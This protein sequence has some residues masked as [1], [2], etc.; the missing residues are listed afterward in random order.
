MAVYT[1]TVKLDDQ[2]TAPAKSAEK[3]MGGLEKATLANIATQGKMANVMAS[4]RD[5]VSSSV[6]GMRSAFS[7]L[8]GGDVRG[9]I[10]GVTDSIAGMAKLLDLVVPGL[11]Q[12]ASILIQIAGGFAGVAAMIVKGG[13]ELAISSSAAK[14]EML[15]LFDAMGQGVVSGEALEGVID[16]LKDKF[17]ISKDRMAGYANELQKLGVTDL[18]KLE[19]GILAMSSA[20]ALSKNG[21]NALLEFQKRIKLAADSGETL[22][23]ADKQLRS[24]G[25]TGA[26]LGAIA[27]IMGT[28]IEKLRSGLKNGTVDAAKF[29]DALEKAVI[30]KGSKALDRLA[31]SAG[32]LKAKWNE[33]IGDLFEDL[34]DSTGP[35][36]AEVGKLLA[37]FSQST[38]SGK[39]MKAGVTAA[40]SAILGVATKVVPYIV[41]FLKDIVIL[42]LKAYIAV[43]PLIAR[44]DA[45]A[46]SADG[47]KT[48]ETIM[49]ALWTVLKGVGV[50]VLIVAGYFGV[51]VAAMTAVSIAVW[52]AVGAFAS[53]A[54]DTAAALAAWVSTAAS[55]AYN[56]VAGL[57]AGISGGIGQ[58]IGAVSGLA[59]SATD[60]FT[61][62]LGIKSPSKVMAELGG[63]MTS[64]L[65]G[66]L[67]AGASDVAGASS[68]MASA[69][70][71]GATSAPAPAAATSGGGGNTINVTVTIDGAGKSAMEIT[72]EM[73]AAVFARM[74]LQAG[75]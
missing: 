22:Q 70:V 15:T 5:A 19:Q 1:E 24:L 21:A 2:V 12:A 33:S 66:G 25:E 7:S 14:Q 47:V 40:F 49:S 55:A 32:E 23:L 69:A 74:A 30:K 61:S 6:D 65:S 48:I 26:D 3:A 29:G 17:G 31:N 62:A 46:K 36:M 4:V 53:F 73:V 10:Q 35:F 28:D 71:K 50:A 11:G 56:F 72:Q 60:T 45:W 16:G 42:S 39:A 54:G 51:M 43:K 18:S 9:A 52:T 20:A 75:A 58:V 67:D 41:N 44:F 38:E 13:I 37:V 68:G 34:S 64:G 57:V 63:H 8:A 59:K 27:K